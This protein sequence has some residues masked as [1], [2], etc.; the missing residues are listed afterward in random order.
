MRMGISSRARAALAPVSIRLLWRYAMS[1][2]LFV[3]V[4]GYFLFSM[5]LY[6]ITDI[7][8]CIPCLWTTVF[9]VHCPGCGLTTATIHLL[10]LDPGGAW[11]ANPLVFLMLPVGLYGVFRDF[12]RFRARTQ[13]APE[14]A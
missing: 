10:Q 14:V 2:W 5:L 8:I 11:E 12:A 9:G 1:Q 7:D 3:L 13:V 6:A 4:G